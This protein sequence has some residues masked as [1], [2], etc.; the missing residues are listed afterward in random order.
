MQSE[1]LKGIG[2]VVQSF[3]EILKRALLVNNLISQTSVESL[4]DPMIQIDWDGK[5]E[6]GQ[7][8]GVQTDWACGA[9]DGHIFF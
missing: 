4:N 9:P 2:V 3:L 1:T 6:C 5:V 7:G 8:N